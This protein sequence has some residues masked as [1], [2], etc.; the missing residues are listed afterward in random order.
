MP[1]IRSHAPWGA[2][3]TKVNS[4]VSPDIIKDIPLK[5]TTPSISKFE[6]LDS[7]QNFHEYHMFFLV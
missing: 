4:D 3:M 7:D 2:G 6:N 5:D 1:N